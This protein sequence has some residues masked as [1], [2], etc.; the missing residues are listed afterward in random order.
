VQADVGIVKADGEVVRA[1][2]GEMKYHMGMLTA[3]HSALQADMG[4]M[5]VDFAV[6]R[7][8]SA[9]QDHVMASKNTLVMW[10]I[11]LTLVGQLMQP[12]LHRLG[13]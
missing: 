10:L 4:T 9:T 8:T 7:A 6:L 5:K 11:S 2:V 3:A 1:D 13:M 12:L